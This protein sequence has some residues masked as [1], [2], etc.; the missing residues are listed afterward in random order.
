VFDAAGQA[1]AE[2]KTTIIMMKNSAKSPLLKKQDKK[3][4]KQ[5]MKKVTF[6]NTIYTLSWN[7]HKIHR[8]LFKKPKCRLKGSPH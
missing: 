8:I 3:Q 4:A 1:A 7:L 2:E 5:Q 6:A